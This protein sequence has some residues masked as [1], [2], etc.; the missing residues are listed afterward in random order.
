MPANQTYHGL[1]LNLQDALLILEGI[2]LDYLPKVQRRLN[3]FERKCI[4]AGSIYAWN[5]NELGMKRWTDGKSWLASK[6]KGPFLI[7]QEHDGS[8]NV[9]PNGLI[10]QSFSLTTK[11]DEK[12]HLIAYYDPADRAKGITTGKIP[13]QDPSLLKLQLDPSVYLND[14]LHYGSGAN[15]QPHLTVN[16]SNVGA[17][18]SSSTLLSLQSYMHPQSSHSSFSYTPSSSMN[19][20]PTLKS[21][22]QS[23]AGNYMGYNQQQVYHT[24]SQP[25]YY[26][27]PLIMSYQYVPTNTPQASYQYPQHQQ[28]Q[29]YMQL[30]PVPGQQYAYG[31]PTMGGPEDAYSQRASVG[32]VINGLP[33]PALS[34]ASSRFSFSA[35][36]TPTTVSAQYSS[37][38]PLTAVPK[39]S[40]ESPTFAYAKN[41]PSSP[42][43]IPSPS[44]SRPAQVY[45]TMK[46]DNS[47]LAGPMYGVP[48]VSQICGS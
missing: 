34:T 3:D 31:M 7:Y 13:S 25:A 12:F 28:Q 36:P 40:V 47:A 1:V 22:G 37:T 9:K 19:S 18:N 6:V 8:R 45:P 29:V 39:S 11:Q 2:R 44:L 5:E 41:T 27:P 42:Q 48:Q 20:V 16:T 35:A 24:L 17:Q 15:N 23:S 30:M 32:S 14:F 46:A 43:S 38:S 10:K 4:V 26:C 21:T 33:T